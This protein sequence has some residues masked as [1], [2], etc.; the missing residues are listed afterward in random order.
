VSAVAAL[1]SSTSLDAAQPHE[2]APFTAIEPDFM[3]RIRHKSYM[4]DTQRGIPNSLRIMTVD[5]PELRH[6][7]HGTCAVDYKASF[8]DGIAPDRHLPDGRRVEQKTLAQSVYNCKASRA[9]GI[10]VLEVSVRSLNPNNVRR[11]APVLNAVEKIKQSIEERT[12]K[13]DSASKKGQ[14]KNEESQVEEPVCA[15]EED[16][17]VAPWN[18]Y[19]WCDELVLRVRRDMVESGGVPVSETA[20]PSNR[21]VVV[22]LCSWKGESGMEP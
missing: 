12:S 2:S 9:V 14:K 10:E 16:E 18:Q 15:T 8:A 19:A 4:K 5:V 7:L 20:K 6:H 13:D 11:N 1:S 22:V 3:D 21:A 17:L